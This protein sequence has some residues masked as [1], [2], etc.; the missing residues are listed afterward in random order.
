MNPESSLSYVCKARLFSAYIK[1]K[2]D[3]INVVSQY[4]ISSKSA[5]QFP[6]WNKLN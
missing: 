2:Y 6:R 5:E 1:V 3:I 4:Q